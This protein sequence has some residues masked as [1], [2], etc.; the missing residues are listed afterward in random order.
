M[1]SPSP[2]DALNVSEALFVSPVNDVPASADT[3]TNG[4]AIADAPLALRETKPINPLSQ[5]TAKSRMLSLEPSPSP[6]ADGVV[7][8][9]V[10][11]AKPEITRRPPVPFPVVSAKETK[12]LS[13]TALADPT[14]QYLI[15][16]TVSPL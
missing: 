15:D 6:V 12:A 11:L 5:S 2:I 13:A 10:P 4:L 16:D 3:A 14:G 9:G 1:A 8:V 7:A